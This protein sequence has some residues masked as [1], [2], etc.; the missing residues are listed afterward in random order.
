MQT[1]SP[2]T[3]LAMSAV[4]ALTLTALA[5]SAAFAKGPGGGAADCDGDCTAD[6][7]QAQPLRVRDGS[8]AQGQGQARRRAVVVAA[9]GAEP[10]AGN[11]NGYGANGNRQNAQGGKNQ[12]NNE[13]AG[14]G[15]NQRGW[16]EGTPPGPGSCEDCDVEMGELDQDGIDGLIYMANEEKLAHD[17]YVKFAEMYGLPVFERIASSEARHQAAV[18]QVLERYGIS[19]DTSTLEAGLFNLP[20]IKELY[21]EL[22]AEG[23]VGL[24]EALAVAV[25][26]EQIDIEDLKLRMAGVEKSAPDVFK[27]YSNLMTASGH[28]EAAFESQL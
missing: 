18:D 11:G 26:I 19:D 25:R 6:Q 9:E 15:G 2:R 10:G 3:L 13:G 5:P 4:V 21:A 23:S 1:R 27:M 22:I 28:H 12:R 24:D 8:G 17:V 14:Q 16:D 20:E 7:T